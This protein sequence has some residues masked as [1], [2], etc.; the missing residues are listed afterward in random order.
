MNARL[1]SCWKGRCKIFQFHFITFLVIANKLSQ[2][3]YSFTEETRDC[4]LGQ[5]SLLKL[6][7]RDIQLSS[8]KGTQIEGKNSRI[9]I[10]THYW[11]F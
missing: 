2:P 6:L 10:Q 3:I 1:L 11:S 7:I 8:I 9:T 4:F 5:E